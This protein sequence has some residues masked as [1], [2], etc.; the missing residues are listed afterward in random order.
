MAFGARHRYIRLDVRRLPGGDVLD[1]LRAEQCAGLGWGETGDLSDITLNRA[2]KAALQTRVAERVDLTTQGQNAAAI[3]NDLFNLALHVDEGDLVVVAD[4]ALGKAIGRI[5]GP[6]EYYTDSDLAHRRP[7]EWIDS[8]EWPCADEKHWARALSWFE[9]SANK[10]AVEQR[11]ADPVVVP[12]PPLAR[13]RGME[14]RVQS[15]LDRKGQVILYGPPGTGKT[16]WAF[17]AAVALI[18]QNLLHKSVEA[19]TADERALV[20]GNISLCT[21]HPAYG[22]EDFLEGYR[23][24][25]R[26]GQ[27]FFKLRD[28]VFKRLCGQ[29]ASHPEQRFILVIDEINR[30][31]IPRI[32]GE[33][34]TLLEKDKRGREVLLPLSGRA[35]SVPTNVFVIGTMNTADRS[36]ALLDTALRR[37]FGFI[38]LLP[39]SGVLG[40]AAVDGLPLGPWLDGLNARLVSAIGPDGRN[41]QIGH[42]YLLEGGH[43]VTTFAG[44]ARIVRDD[45]VPLLQEYCYEDYRLL[46]QILGTSLVDAST[47]Q[48]HSELFGEESRED[49]KLAL[50][51]IAPDITVSAQAVAAEVDAAVEAS[52]EDAI[53][54]SQADVAADA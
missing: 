37:R 26:D 52:E 25:E 51:A 35:F 20:E 40:D 39:D 12:L 54:E 18:A 42:A 7:V 47:Q 45:I 21:F 13:L 38:E 29:A 44:F 30:G 34:L 53:D 17:R 27:L 5:S 43:P 19:L 48:V 3:T 15:I 14:G 36:I 31:D 41:L 11:L 4:G 28:G 50:V 24:E 32:F 1:T 46:E 8:S 16:Y 22:Y 2:G 23:P 33:L 9:Q 6:Y 10:L 49:L